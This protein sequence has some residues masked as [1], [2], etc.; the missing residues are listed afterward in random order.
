MRFKN[1]IAFGGVPLFI[2]SLVA[3]ALREAM[4]LDPSKQAQAILAVDS[5]EPFDLPHVDPAIRI[6]DDQV[7]V[8]IPSATGATPVDQSHYIDAYIAPPTARARAVLESATR[9]KI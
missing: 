8:T 7:D 2:F 5:R 3:P 9:R 4:S 6:P 1:C